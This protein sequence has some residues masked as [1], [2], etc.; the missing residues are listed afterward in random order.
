MHEP[1]TEPW[2]GVD[3][4]WLPLGAGDAPAVVRW[5]GRLFEALVAGAARRD[6]CDLYHSALEVRLD[7]ARFTIEM[8]PVWDSR[9]HGRDV[10][11]EGPVGSRRLGHLRL[12]RYEVRRWREGSIPDV[13]EAVDSP[14][15]LSSDPER[16]RALLNLVDRFPN[17]TWGRDEQDA[18]EM[19]NSNSLTSW[20]L[21]GS[22]HDLTDVRPPEG[23]RAPGWD[24]GI[25]VA[26]RAG[27]VVPRGGTPDGR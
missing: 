2:C 22:G 11:C 14:R 16:A 10:V 27:T 17:V 19:W 25:V 26:R 9:A 24:A 6:R 7:G 1:A 5:S 3:L 15:R 12:F 8:G 18:G 20:L 21:V 4:F 13:D 23:G